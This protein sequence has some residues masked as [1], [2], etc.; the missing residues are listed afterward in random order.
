MEVQNENRE[1]KLHPIALHWGQQEFIQGKTASKYN[2]SLSTSLSNVCRELDVELV[3][4]WN[5]DNDY[6]WGGTGHYKIAA[7]AC[8]I[9]S[10]K[11][12]KKLLAANKDNIAFE[13][14]AML[15][16]AIKNIDSKQFC[17]LADV[18][19]LVWRNTRKLD[20][21]NHFADMDES[22]S[23]VIDGKTL[24]EA[25]KNTSNIDVD[26]WNSYYEG[27]EAEDS[28]KS[29]LK[30]GALP[31]R[32]WQAFDLMVEYVKQGKLAEFICVGGTVS[33][34]LGDACQPLHISFLH[35]GHP[36][37]NE[38]KVHA[39][40]ETQMMDSKM[41]EL[42]NGVNKK[43]LNKTHN[44]NTYKTGKEAARSVIKLMDKVCNDILSP[45]EVIEAFNEVSG[46]GRIKN[47]WEKL[48]DRTIKCV[49]EGSINLALFWE[50]AWTA[51]D[52]DTV[53]KDA[54]LKTIKKDKLS[55]LYNDKTF[56]PSF[57]LKDP[58]FKA[59]LK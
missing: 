27:M 23:N 58:K 57:R 14:D 7:L 3:R 12:L 44:Y 4:G 37:K 36:G 29:S 21:A 54:D 22:N 25:C 45:E 53:F 15:K 40:Y 9:V 1:T 32:V 19:D 52:G 56:F 26:F 38:S 17:P 51:G 55:D 47:M 33:H 50:S 59:A 35:H 31:F 43:L 34:Y 20:E 49:A 46:R 30:R 16:D 42:F 28:S 8:D 18:P 48:G 11:K 24:L 6:S 10:T 13:D 39:A 41:Q 5:I 2:L